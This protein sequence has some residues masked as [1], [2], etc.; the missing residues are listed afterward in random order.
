MTISEMVDTMLE[1]I[2]LNINNIGIFLIQFTN[3]IGGACDQ[4]PNAIWSLFRETTQ[5]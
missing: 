5:F 2:D 3:P 1:K 4:D